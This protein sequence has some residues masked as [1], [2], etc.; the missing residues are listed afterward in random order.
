[1]KNKLRKFIYRKLISYYKRKRKR[2]RIS[3]LNN[4]EKW[5]ECK[6]LDYHD[7]ARWFISCAADDGLKIDYCD[8]KIKQLKYLI[9]KI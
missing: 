8:N 2:L 7:G 9:S 4:L 1:M 6:D 3:K 5:Q